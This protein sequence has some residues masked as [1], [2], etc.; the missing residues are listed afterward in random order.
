MMI[1]D[2][3]RELALSP[4]RALSPV[5]GTA[6]IR[7][8]ADDFAVDEELGFAPSGQG[9]HVLMRVRKRDANTGWVAGELARVAGVRPL[10]VG[11][12]GLKDRRAVTTQ[13][14]TVPGRPRPAAEWPGVAGEGFEVLEAHAHSRKLPRGALAGNRFRIV[15]RDFRGDRAMLERRILGVA[16]E[17]VPNYFGPQR[18]GREQSN[19]R[20]LMNPPAPR[21]PMDRRDSGRRGARD[22]GRG[23][24]GFVLSAARSLIFNAV[25]ARRVREGSWSTLLP[26]ER[27]NLDGRNSVFPV[28]VLDDELVDRAR[29]LDLHPTGPLWGEG[30]SGVTGDVAVLEAQVAESFPEARAVIHACG[31]EPSRRPL[32]LRV[33]ELG[34]SWLEDGALELRFGLRPGGFATAVIRELIDVEG[35]QEAEHD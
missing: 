18:F 26:G 10:D 24:G 17:G 29:R 31:A 1:P 22:R 21:A 13:W 6:R 15:L 32:R 27:A 2:A 30:E 16:A 34:F 28:P 19:L 11:Y 12:A 14:F 20:A 8:L 4:P 33:G 5:A 25:L 9:E 7:E 35:F 3:W 23:D